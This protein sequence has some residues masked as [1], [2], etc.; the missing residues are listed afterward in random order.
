MRNNRPCFIWRFF[1]V[2]NSTYLT[3]TAAS[4]REARSQLPAVRPVFVARIRPEA[5]NHA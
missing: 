2:Q 3:T 5:M 4:E 1:S